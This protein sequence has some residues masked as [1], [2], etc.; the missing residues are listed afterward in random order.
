VKIKATAIILAGILL[1]ALLPAAAASGEDYT[2]VIRGGETAASVTTNNGETLL[3]V[4]LFLNGI[5]DSKLLTAL[6]FDLSFDPGKA[7]YIRSSQDTG[8]RYLC[9]V[10][11]GGTVVSYPTFL[12]NDTYAEQGI[13]R[14]VLAS[15]YG[16]RIKTDK[17]MIS[18]FFWMTPQLEQGT[19][20]AF[21]IGDD[22]EA[23]SV[24]RSAQGSVG[25]E[26]VLRTVG[27]DLT[28]FTVSETT[29]D[30]MP[31]NA[32]VSFREEDVSYRGATPYVVFAYKA[33]TP[34]VVV[35]NADTG[36]VVDPAY[37]TVSYR[38]N[39]KAGTAN[40]DVTFRYCYSGT[41]SGWFKIYLPKTTQTSVLNVANGI[42]I[43][44]KEVRGAAGYVIYRR[45]WNL[46]SAGWTSFERWNNTTE[47]TWTDTKV[48]A[49]TR[50]QYGVKAYP[51]DPMD[52]YNLG[53]VGPLK[54]TVR[55]TT[56][57]L[58]SVT[59][60]TKKLTAKWDAS[61]N[62]TGYQV[63]IATDSGFEQN[64]QTFTI[65]NAQTT[66]YTVKNLKSSKTYYVR[67]RSYTV[68]EGTTYYGQWSN[69]RSCKVK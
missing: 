52:N 42:K 28:P 66:S 50:Y 58:N 26:Y 4:D 32:T 61:K 64:R 9:A 27:T 46:I 14:F 35:T 56:R 11:S 5:D 69:V 2:I 44:W 38:D 55:I 12:I 67:V 39:D 7:A 10:N 37:Y 30:S 53:I 31:I 45:A 47:T 57:T 60:G 3:R 23:E 63:Q 48:Y 1:L 16:C 22:I 13:L 19:A 21:A 29:P 49:G 20:I 24:R 51:V 8:E 36:A 41:A 65:D 40:A 17:P 54:T 68:F 25:A 59:A 18:L 33:H 6:S 62:F 15:D 34:R 43:S